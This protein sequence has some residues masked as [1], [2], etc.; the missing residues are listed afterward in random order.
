MGSKALVSCVSSGLKAAPPTLMQNL[1][2]QLMKAGLVSKE[3]SDKAEAETARKKEEA[4]KA[5]EQRPAQA[6]SRPPPRHHGHSGSSPPKYEAPI[7]KLPP[8]PGSKAHQR[9][10]ALRQ[11]ELDRRIRE[12]VRSQEVLPE[13]GD[14]RFHFMTRKGKLRRLEI[15]SAQQKLLEEGKLAIAERPEPA[16]IEHSIIPREIAEQ[17]ITL[18]EKSVRFY[19][20]DGKPIGFLTDEELAYQPSTESEVN[21]EGQAAEVTAAEPEEEA[22]GTSETPA[23]EEKPAG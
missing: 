15:S 4:R 21:T 20:R 23:V 12:L 3:Q 7:P 14:V 1:R 8:M 11:V 6:S 10:E 13:I 17:L 19:N 18:S 16:M 9:L 22:A 5:R 2:D